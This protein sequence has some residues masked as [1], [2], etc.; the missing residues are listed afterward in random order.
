MIKIGITGGIG[1]G[2][3]VVAEL[4]SLYGVP[5]FIADTES[6]RIVDSSDM[7]RE[8]LISLFGPSIYTP[9]GLDRKQ[10]ASYI[11]QDTIV[12]NQV[13]KIIH[14]VVSNAF[15]QWVDTQNSEFTVI[16]SA[17]LFESKFD[18]LVDVTLTINAPLALR[19]ERASNR[20]KCD[21]NV[22]KQRI[23]HQT[24]DDEKEIRANYVIL[25][26]NKTSLIKQIEVFITTI[27][28]KKNDSIKKSSY[29][30]QI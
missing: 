2:K 10:L 4:L 9:D 11:F 29:N 14:P 28:Q 20:D 3:S 8:Q 19:I 16:E 15:L 17:I 26:N 5:C 6:K 1:S 13:N 24:T 21:A 25:N 18:H 30:L 27:T 7:I 22:I 23:K 12:L